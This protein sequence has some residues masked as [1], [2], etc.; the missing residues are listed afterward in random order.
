MV[1]EDLDLNAQIAHPQN[2]CRLVLRSPLLSSLL[3]FTS[4]TL[5]L[6]STVNINSSQNILKNLGKEHERKKKCKALTE[7]VL[8]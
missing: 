2:F 5:S 7:S 4:W 8:P 3:V 1:R 6:S